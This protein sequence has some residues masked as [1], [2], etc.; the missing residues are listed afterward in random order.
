MTE[1]TNTADP[2]LL[3]AAVGESVAKALEVA[4]KRIVLVSF[5]TSNA[6]VIQQGSY[7][8]PASM[9]RAELQTLS[10]YA[11]PAGRDYAYFTDDPLVQIGDLVVVAAPNGTGPAVKLPGETSSRRLTF[12]RVSSVKPS[13]REGAKASQWIVGRVDTRKW[14]ERVELAQRRELLEKK[15]EKT[16]EALRKRV[17]MQTLAAQHPELAELMKEL[18]ELNS[19][20][21]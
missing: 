10:Q 14:L 20:R 16:A 19:A 17:E 5:D 15:I 18:D 2:N 1:E 7:Y 3:D 21:A 12:A 11:S 8:D 9:T 4:E 6:L 13:Y